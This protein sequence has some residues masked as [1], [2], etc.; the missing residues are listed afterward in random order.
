MA[1]LGR[2]DLLSESATL[3][4][5]WAALQAA[6]RARGVDPRACLF[7]ST[8]GFNVPMVEVFGTDRHGREQGGFTEGWAAGGYRGPPRAFAEVVFGS[9][10]E[11]VETQLRTGQGD[12]AL[13]K[14]PDTPDA[15]LLAYRRRA[16]VRIHVKQYAFRGRRP[17]AARRA[18]VLVMR[19]S[20]LQTLAPS[21]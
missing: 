11:E 7:R 4:A 16:L 3:R 14:C 2:A 1:A 15:H 17:D 10:F 6:L 13:S 8:E 5:A 19:V 18:L 21:P 9:T 20:P 12:S